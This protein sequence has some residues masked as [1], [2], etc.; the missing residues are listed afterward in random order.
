MKTRILV[1]SL[2]LT[3]AAGLT[4]VYAQADTA[5]AQVTEELKALMQKIADAWCT[6]DPSKAAPFYVT[7]G[8]HVFYDISPLKYTGWKQ[9]ADGAG[10]MFAGVSSLKFTLGKDVQTHRRGSMAWGTATLQVELTPK[11]GKTENLAAR[12]TVIWEKRGDNWLLVHEHVSAPLPPAPEK[13]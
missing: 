5:G 1:L 11:D 12:W 7:E 6:L 13:K 10:K 4:P 8:P 9:Y 3:L 2:A